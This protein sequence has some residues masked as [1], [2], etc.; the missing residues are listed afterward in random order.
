L[1]NAL[2]ARTLNEFQRGTFRV[3][4]DVIDVFLLMQIMRSEFS[5]LE[6]KLKKFKVLILFQ[7]M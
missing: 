7:E 5:F 2:Y 6:M 3:K 1:V 4:G